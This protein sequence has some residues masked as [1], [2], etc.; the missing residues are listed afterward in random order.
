PTWD[1]LAS[2]GDVE[3]YARSGGSQ[4]VERIGD[5]EVAL[6]NKTPITADA[7]RDLPSL[8]YIGVLATGV[9]VV[10]VA[11]AKER[12]VLV[13]NVPGYSTDSVAQHVFALL[14]ELT[15]RVAAHDAAVHEGEWVGSSD[16]CFTVA[17]LMELAGKNLGVVGLGDIGTRVARI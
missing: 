15:N 11:A 12:G 3:V 17:P 9:N 16:F 14:L 2:L 8:K 1:A 13:A 6:T 7:I 10:D 5:A 4:I